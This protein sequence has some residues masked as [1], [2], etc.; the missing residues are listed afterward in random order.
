MAR[1]IINK[2]YG[3]VTQYNHLSIAK[4][5]LLKADNCNIRRENILESRRGNKL[6]GALSNAP[7]QTL[8]YDDT[9]LV[10]NGTA[11]S[12]DDGTGT[13]ADYSGSFSEVS[14]SRLHASQ[15]KQNLYVTTSTGTRV[16]Q[17]T[18]G[19]DVRTAGAPRCLDLTYTLSAAGSGFLQNGYQCA[20][21][22]TIKRTDANSNILI[23][24]PSQ[25]LW[26]VNASGVD[27]TVSLLI[28][29]PS[30]VVEG[31]EVQ[32]FRT[33][34]IAGTT[35]DISGDEMG[36]IYTVAVTSTDVTNGYVSF[37]DS[38]DDDLRGEDLYTNPSQQG[39]TQANAKPPLATDIDLFKGFMFYANTQSRQRLYLTLVGTTSLTGKTI[40]LAGVTYNFGATEIT[41]GA[42]SPQA[43]V[44][45]TGVA[46]V[47]IDETARSLVRVI[48]RFASNT[49]VYAYYISGTSDLPGAILIEARTLGT[50]VFTAQGEDTAIGAMFSPD[51]PVSP[52]TSSR[53][54]SSADQ[55]KNGLY[56]SKDQLPEAVPFANFYLVGPSNTEIL[57]IQAL[58]DSLIVIKEE[59]VYRL[60]GEDPS[61][62]TVVPLDLTV[63]CK[64]PESV[65]IL[66]NR[67]FM[68]SNQGVVAISDTGVEVVSRAIE[69]ELVGKIAFSEI[70]NLAFGVGYSSDRSYLLSLPSTSA[71]EVNEE[72]FVYNYFTNTWTRYT[73]G[74]TSAVIEDTVDKLFYVKSSAN[75]VFTER[76][77]LT[78]ADYADPEYSITISDITDTVV[79]FTTSGDTPKIGWTVK[80][81]NTHIKIIAIEQ[82]GSDWIATLAYEPPGSWTTG[83]ADL[84]PGV[85]F[86]VEWAAWSAEAP[87]YLKQARQFLIM[88]DNIV[89]NSVTT[90]IIATFRTDL[91]STKEE[92]TIDSQTDSWGVSPWGQFGWGGLADTYSY[93]TYVPRDKQYFRLMNSGVKMD[94]SQE[95]ISLAGISY[96]FETISERV[97]R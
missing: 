41:S 69:P 59:G 64:A 76:K 45:A 27:D 16:L 85:G 70:S 12:Y 5:A 15:A 18:S 37:V 2:C 36:L 49:S 92:I 42:G 8:V 31:D 82:S 61:S 25:R 90:S 60:T 6:Y 68:L 34:T 7:K 22:A 29:L 52:A 87:D 96:V 19:G 53:A 21:R 17:S 50:S 94:N 9:I 66:D 86:E 91:S 44:S 3:W 28:Y 78:L 51:L 23:G 30:E 88:T 79:T 40:T 93:P 10:H 97:R 89:G 1:D 13:F 71:S 35:E 33:E 58:R 83:A 43:K 95:K 46:S 39:I 80:Q 77:D 32:V 57:R 48:N 54:T 14:G 26:A 65:A 84:F 62:F 24:Y 55:R 74:F 63:K 72:T 56:F 4:G 81:G 47:D 75:S 67:V 38:I 73:F 11:L 20:Y